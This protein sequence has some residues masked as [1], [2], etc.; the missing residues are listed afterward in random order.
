MARDRAVQSPTAIHGPPARSPRTTSSRP[1]TRNPPAISPGKSAGPYF[2]PGKA[3]KPWTCQST[4]APRIASAAPVSASWNFNLLGD[5]DG[6]HD[7]AVVG[8][9]LRHELR[10][11][12]GIRP[13]HAEAAARHEVLVVL[14]VVDLL[15]RRAERLL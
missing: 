12:G 4:T 3:G 1:Q 7:G 10:R 2:W 11:L 6:L 13:H 14:R 8:V 9:R 15:E 5:A